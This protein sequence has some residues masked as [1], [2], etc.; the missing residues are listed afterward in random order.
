MVSIAI[1]EIERIESP[2][3]I[4]FDELFTNLKIIEV[5]ALE[6]SKR[7]PFKV[8]LVLVLILIG[9]LGKLKSSI[10][11]RD[12]FDLQI[13]RFKNEAHLVNVVN[14]ASVQC[15]RLLIHTGTITNTKELVEKAR[16]EL[17]LNL[18]DLLITVD[19]ISKIDFFDSESEL[20]N[21][22][23]VSTKSSRS[24]LKLQG[25]K[26]CKVKAQ[27]SVFAT[28]KK[29]LKSLVVQM[30]I[31]HWVKNLLVFIPLLAAH[32]V[33]FA[34]AWISALAYFFFAEPNRIGHLHL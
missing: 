7:D 20:K 23:Y 2:L 18:Q 16:N 22:L 4:S 8:F 33:L 32:K 3:V 26:F 12:S 29:S 28:S 1:E 25:L 10:S 34:E 6:F 14:S 30:R 21:F 31:R 15:R 9:F 24:I 11:R 13:V 17:G 19:E 5:N 27:E